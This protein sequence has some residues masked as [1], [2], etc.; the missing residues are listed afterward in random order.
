MTGVLAV[1]VASRK[2]NP[3]TASV[4][5]G[6]N[7]AGFPGPATSAARTLTVPAGNPGS[8]TITASNA[9]TSY[10]KNGGGFTNFTSTT[11]AFANGDTLTFRFDLPSGGITTVTVT[12][13]TTGSSIGGWTGSVI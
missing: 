1:I 10:S 11:V 13:A 3:I 2:V 4:N 6:S 5:W 8:I 7:S 12:D 9:T